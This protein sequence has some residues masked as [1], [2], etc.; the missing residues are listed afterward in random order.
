MTSY[1]ISALIGYLVGSFPTAY[2]LVK[3]KTKVDIRQAGSGNVG[4][5]NTMEVTSS[6]SLGVAVLMIDMVKGALP[7][8][9]VMN[10]GGMQFWILG[11]AGLSAIIGH[12]FPLWL[13]FKG[14]RG[15]ATTAGVMLVLGWVFIVIWLVLWTLAYLSTRNIHWGNILASMLSPILVAVMPKSILLNTLPSYTSTNDLLYFGIAFCALILITH[16]EYLIAL[17]RKQETL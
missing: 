17:I 9:L 2:L 4:T 11:V 1:I 5:L 15:L 12:S 14:G 8:L 16:R 7:V 6:K 3:W 10:L 13:K